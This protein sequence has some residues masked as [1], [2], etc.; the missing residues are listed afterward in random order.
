MVPEHFFVETAACF[1][2]SFVLFAARAATA[3]THLVEAPWH[4]ARV[5]PMLSETWTIRDNVTVADAL[6]VVLARHVHGELV[7]VDTELAAAPSLGVT[8]R[9]P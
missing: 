4:R 3:L 2:A 1:D 9:V 8:V 5:L 6:Y 7:T